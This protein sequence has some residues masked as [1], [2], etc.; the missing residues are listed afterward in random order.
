MYGLV[1]LKTHAKCVLVVRR[2]DHRMRRYAH[3]G[4]GNYN[5]TTAA[6]YEDG[7][8]FNHLTGFSAVG[9]YRSLVVAPKHL[10]NE[11]LRLIAV[12]ASFGQAG[13]IVI[14]SNAVVDEEMIQALYRASQAGVAI[15]LIVRG[16]C[17]LRPG[18]E[19]L[20]K[21]VRSI[22]GRFLEHSRIYSF[23]NGAGVG[24]EALLMGSADLMER[25]LDRRVEVLVR[26]S[27]QMA[28]G[29]RSAPPLVAALR[30][31]C[32]RGGSVSSSRVLGDVAYRSTGCHEGELV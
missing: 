6:I 4:T 11:L 3:I 7:G 8:L 24:R 9:S 17:C 12:E 15:D 18:V 13:C 30:T 20:S 23:A 29:P 10:R 26:P 5:A 19:G 31:G 32:S 27:A 22:L 25:N 14:K 16:A 2:E 21:G 28:A 1:G